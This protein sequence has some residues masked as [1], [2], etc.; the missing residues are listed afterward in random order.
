V[1]RLQLEALRT[2][3][4]AACEAGQ[5]RHCFIAAKL[6]G[7]D[8]G[9]AGVRFYQ[10]GC[11][12]GDAQCC[13]DWGARSWDEESRAAYRRSIELRVQGCE[14]GKPVDCARLQAFAGLAAEE[15]AESVSNEAYRQLFG[16][17]FTR[18]DEARFARRAAELFA[19]ICR[20]G[21]PPA[22]VSACELGSTAV[23]C[24]AP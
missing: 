20:R 24:D 1:A 18:E 10:R 13:F 3:A 16:R 7:D 22:C 21:Y 15:P 2:R 4:P 6:A 5:A 8:V 12:L 17:D 14:R 11:E 9:G 19:A 23:P